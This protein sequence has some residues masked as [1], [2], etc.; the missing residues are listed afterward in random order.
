MDVVINQY[1]YLLFVCRLLCRGLSE[2]T[3][4][5][6]DSSKQSYFGNVLGKI[7]SI[8][9]L[10]HINLVYEVVLL[11]FHLCVVSL[12]PFSC[13]YS[14]IG[15]VIIS[16]SPSPTW[17]GS[18]HF[19]KSARSSLCCILFIQNENRPWWDLRTSGRVNQSQYQ[20]I[21]WGLI[22]I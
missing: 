8:F 6:F 5:F 10:L 15:C 13:S 1:C 12:L 2:S 17:F 11:K 19:W 4:G 21:G 14:Y 20:R 22:G 3:F 18:V 7:Y 16:T 9:L